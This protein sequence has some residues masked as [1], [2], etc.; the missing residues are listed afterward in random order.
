MPTSWMSGQPQPAFWDLGWGHSRWLSQVSGAVREV[1]ST[2]STRRPWQP[3]RVGVAAASRSP[4][5]H[6]SRHSQSSGR[7][8]RA[9]QNALLHGL[10]QL[11]L[12]RCHHA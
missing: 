9:A 5:R 11:R 3:G 2:T 6:Q 12:R 4:A 1:P 8:A 7:R 10:D